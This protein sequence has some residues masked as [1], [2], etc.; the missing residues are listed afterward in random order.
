M[1]GPP[2]VAA[3]LLE[4]ALAASERDAV[5]GDLREEYCRYIVPSRGAAAARRWYWWQ[6]ARSVAPLWG[7]AWERAS[8]SRAVTAIVTAALAAMVPALLLVLLR[9]FVLQ[10]VPLKTTAELSPAFAFSLLGVFLL[11]GALG[12]AAALGV[13]NADTRNR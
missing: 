10:Q 8:L 12:L 4:A 3:W 6:V 11:T 13:L 1:T 9:S 2:P 7:R 5:I